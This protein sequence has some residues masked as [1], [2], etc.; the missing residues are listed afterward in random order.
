MANLLLR[1]VLP[2]IGSFSKK[3]SSLAQ[4]IFMSN[5]EVEFEITTLK[6]TYVPNFSKIEQK[7]GEFK[8]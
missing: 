5:F 1:R 7:M 3:W 8:F 4:I 2:N 6:L